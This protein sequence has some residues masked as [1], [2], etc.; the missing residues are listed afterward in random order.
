MKR[1]PEIEVQFDLNVSWQTRLAA[2]VESGVGL[3]VEDR[4]AMS[5]Q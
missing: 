5:L 2:Q 3:Q 4:C 1:A